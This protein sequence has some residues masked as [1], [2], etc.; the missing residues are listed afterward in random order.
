MRGHRSYLVGVAIATACGFF[1]P[2]AQADHHVVR[3]SEVFAGSTMFSTE[4]VELQ[5]T[6]AGQRFFDGTNSTLTLQGPT[7]LNTATVPVNADVANGQRGRRVLIGDP[8]L[9]LKTPDFPAPTGNNMTPSG[10][11][12]CFVSGVNGPIDCVSWGTFA[13]ST[14]SPT[15]GNTPAISDP[16]ALHRNVPP[17]ADGLVDTNSPSDWTIGVPTPNNNADPPATGESC[18]NTTITKHPKKKA[19]KRRAK[20]AFTATEG[21]DEFQCKLDNRPFKDCASPYKKRVKLGKHKFKVKA[22]GDESPAS[23]GWKVV[24]KK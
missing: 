2:P 13:G 11:A 22:D 19:T 5:M 1:A 21:V 9:S 17:C 4:Y 10:G 23:Y 3:I 16:N 12:A 18:P 15:G 24:K 8:G 7:G 14:V 20:F 6:S